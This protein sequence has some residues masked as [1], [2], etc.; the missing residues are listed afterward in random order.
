[1]RPTKFIHFADWAHINT[2]SNLIPDITNTINEFTSK[3]DIDAII[4]NGDIGY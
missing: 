1:M 2:K 4:I 3:G